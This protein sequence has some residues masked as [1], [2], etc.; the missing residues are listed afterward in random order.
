VTRVDKHGKLQNDVQL[1]TAKGDAADVAIVWA[2]NG[3]IVAW[4]DGRAGNG[5]VFATKI[6]V[7]L[8]R[9]ARE[10]RITDAPGDASD[11]TLMARGDR[12]WLAWADPRESPADG[13]A[14][15]FVTQIFAHDAKRAS[16]E[17]RVLAS[18]AHSRSPSLAA[19]ADGVAIGWIE[20]AP[21]GADAT[22][23]LAHGAMIVKLDDHGRPRGAPIKVRGAGDGF[24]TAIALET[25]G[26]ALHGVVARGAK[27]EL[28]VDAIELAPGADN[29]RAFPLMTLDGPP[30]LDVSLSLLGGA[31]Y[32]N[33]DGPEPGDRR[34]RRAVISWNKDAGNPNK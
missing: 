19:T 2:G 30:S 17:V 23:S 5:E 20:D 10:E 34:A 26:T 31:L 29:V 18:A 8:N 9:V 33:D 27:E 15:I 3:W 4:V 7:D 24:P 13:F 1:T 12:V 6:G 25:A 14:D 28:D 22:S 11:V 32:Y 16:D 21:M